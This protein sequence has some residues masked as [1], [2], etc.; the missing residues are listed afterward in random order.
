[1]L[2]AIRQKSEIEAAPQVD[3]AGP[4]LKGLTFQSLT[5]DDKSRSAIAVV[6]VPNEPLNVSESTH[7]AF[8]TWQLREGQRYMLRIPTQKYE[9]V[10]VLPSG[11]VTDDG[12]DKIVFVEDGD[13][14]KPAKVVILYQD[15]EVAV[16]DEEHS[17][18][19]IGDSVV[20]HGAFG[21]GLALKAG[22][23]AVDPHAGH[24]H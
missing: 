3:E 2:N 19:Y 1:M 15:D 16:L 21:L 17:E 9:K 12:P 7:G 13:S 5:T 23:G 11:A 24:S 4:R 22:S 20:Q 14:F 18:I 10:F 8:R 6:R